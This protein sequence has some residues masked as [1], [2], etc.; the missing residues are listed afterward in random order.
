M[1]MMRIRDNV[2]A[3]KPARG[4]VVATL[5]DIEAAEP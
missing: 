2:E 4:T 3:E 5:D 1:A